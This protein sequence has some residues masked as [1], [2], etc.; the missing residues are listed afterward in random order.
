MV[1]LR[2]RYLT[3]MNAS[4]MTAMMARG[5]HSVTDAPNQP[6]LVVSDP[7]S[8]EPMVGARFW[9]ICMTLMPMPCS[10]YMG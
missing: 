7:N 2:P 1:R 5:T 4:A 8:G 3:F 10:R 9:E 6:M